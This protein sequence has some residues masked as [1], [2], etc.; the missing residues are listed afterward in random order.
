VNLNYYKQL[1]ISFTSLV[2]TGLMNLKLWLNSNLHI[3]YQYNI[4]T[5]VS[6]FRN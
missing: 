1:L 6:R 3:Q 2:V 4:N 5:P